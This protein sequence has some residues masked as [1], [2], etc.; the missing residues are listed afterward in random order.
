MARR[1]RLKPASSATARSRSSPA[2]APSASPTSWS[3]DDGVQITVEA[4]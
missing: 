2:C 1:N 4:A 3:S